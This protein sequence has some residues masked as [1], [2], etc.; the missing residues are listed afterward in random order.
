M[1]LI[2]TSTLKFETFDVDHDV[3]PY[4]ILSHTWGADE[5]SYQDML[6]SRDEA[7]KKQ[8]FDKIEKCAELAD[9][10]NISYC[11]V[12]TCC[13]DKS[14]STELSEAINSMFRWYKGASVCYAYLSDIPPP[15]S[16][17]EWLL[18]QVE[19]YSDM[20]RS[21][22]KNWAKKIGAS[23]WFTRGWT[24]QELIAPRK[25]EFYSQDWTF[26]GTKDN[27]KDHISDITGIP[28]DVLSSSDVSNTPI[29]CRMSWAANRLTSRTEDIAYC[30]LGIMEINMPLLYG[31]GDRAFIRLQKE[32]I[33]SSDDPTIFLWTDSSASFSKCSGVLARS[34]SAFR[35]LK[36]FTDFSVDLASKPYRM[37]NKGLKISLQLIPRE[38]YTD[39]FI[40][41]LPGIQHIDDGKGYK[42]GVYLAQVGEG[43][44]L[45]VDVNITMKEHTD[46]THDEPIRSIIIL[47]KPH[48]QAV[49][50][51]HRRVAG[52]AITNRR[53]E[54]YPSQR[55]RGLDV[56]ISERE[57]SLYFFFKR[58][59]IS[60]EPTAPRIFFKMKQTSSVLQWDV[61]VSA[62]SKLSCYEGS[63]YYGPPS[64]LGKVTVTNNPDSH[65]AKG[66]GAGGAGVGSASSLYAMIKKG[67]R[68]GEIMLI[69]DV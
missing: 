53:G 50:K 30:L 16:Y 23:R 2:N 34:P 60:A 55:V 13:I 57:H 17:L 19:R 26:A 22:F 20:D 61:D 9:R 64:H 52:I 12:D 48:R 1:R 62:I 66:I 39:E 46:Q 65:F 68:Y 25:L 35:D 63:E 11:W 14:S 33:S 47:D 45:R 59:S 28:I 21:L 36:E 4:A 54:F 31:E 3:P 43:A 24:L 7:E 29:A 38:G 15:S 51:E 40:A 8:G 67:I 58:D 10:N 32:L 44:F 5:V 41:I 6:L 37:T 49:P 27:L 18:G 42:Y 56:D 69:V